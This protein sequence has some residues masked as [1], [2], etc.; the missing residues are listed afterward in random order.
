MQSWHS[1]GADGVRKEYIYVLL[2]SK[3]QRLIRSDKNEWV[4]NKALER[5]LQME[6]L[7]SGW[8]SISQLQ[9][10]FVGLNR[11]ESGEVCGTPQE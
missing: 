2:K 5:E 9:Q 8:K 10:A 7:N 11:S 1:S 3:V 4:A 6:R